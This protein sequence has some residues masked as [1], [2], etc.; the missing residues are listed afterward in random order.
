[1]NLES[2]TYIS[3]HIKLKCEHH[4]EFG[5]LVILRKQNRLLLQ[6][7]LQ[8]EKLN[9]VILASKRGY[10]Y[11][12]SIQKPLQIQYQVLQLLLCFLAGAGGRCTICDEC[13][14]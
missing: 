12:D 7:A 8:A 13:E 3:G 11:P 9:R 2:C 6:S 14:S 1:M 5:V 10:T 4:G